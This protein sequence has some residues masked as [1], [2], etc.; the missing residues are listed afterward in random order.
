MIRPSRRALAV[1][2]LLIGL[3]AARDAVCRPCAAEA[4]ILTQQLAATGLMP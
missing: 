2:A 3:M 1:L 4:A